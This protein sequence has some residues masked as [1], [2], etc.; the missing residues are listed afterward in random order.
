MIAYQPIIGKPLP[1]HAVRERRFFY[2]S[3]ADDV[4]IAFVGTLA[5]CRKYIRTAEAGTYHLGHNESGRPALHVVRT[6]SL[7]PWAMAQA[8]AVASHR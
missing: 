8:C 1:S 4:R 2:D 7:S 6:A 5:Q 3:V